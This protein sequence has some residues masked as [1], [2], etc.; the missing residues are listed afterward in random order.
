[1]C[2][3]LL[4]ASWLVC[5]RAWRTVFACGFVWGCSPKVPALRAGVHRIIILYHR[6]AYLHCMLGAPW[7]T[8]QGLVHIL[9][10]LLFDPWEKLLMPVRV[11]QRSREGR[12]KATCQFCL[13]RPATTAAWGPLLFDGTD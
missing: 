12:S 6:Q 8:V 1:M 11:L 9:S 5:F 13:R 2:S 7:V 4:C 10:R 3:P